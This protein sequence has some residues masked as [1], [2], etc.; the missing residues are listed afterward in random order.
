MK[1]FGCTSFLSVADTLRDV[2]H[3]T[4][5]EMFIALKIES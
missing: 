1:I 4:R 5:A 2:E 3:G